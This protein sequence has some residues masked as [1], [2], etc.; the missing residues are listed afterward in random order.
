MGLPAG[1]P[2][3]ADVDG[4]LLVLPARTSPMELIGHLAGGSWWDILRL[5]DGDLTLWSRLADPFDRFGV[6]AAARVVHEVMAAVTGYSWYT[7]C[8][9]ASAAAAD[10]PAFDGLCAYRGFDPWSA[11]IARTLALV[12]HLLRQQCETPG[13]R[14]RLEFELAGPDAED[15]ND[16]RALAA[17][18]RMAAAWAAAFNSDGTA[19]AQL[20]A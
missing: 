13:E 4:T 17:E 6:V 10:W 3:A 2:V 5:M 1:L 16:A 14:A 19:K 7:A 18:R 8:A 9:L 11:P 15:G 12:H 20:T